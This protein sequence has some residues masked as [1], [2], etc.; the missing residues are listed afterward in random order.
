MIVRGRD[1]R[2]LNA[3]IMEG[4]DDCSVSGTEIQSTLAWIQN[5]K[6]TVQ[7]RIVH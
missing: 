4:G 7:E 2:P 5:P 1:G 6:L 3:E